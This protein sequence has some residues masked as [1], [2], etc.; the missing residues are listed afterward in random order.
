MLIEDA[1]C[2]LSGRNVS[3]KKGVYTPVP[4]EGDNL[5]LYYYVRELFHLIINLKIGM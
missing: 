1:K 2:G 4:R 5:V 3:M